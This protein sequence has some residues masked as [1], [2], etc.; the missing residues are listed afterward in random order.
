MKR[1]NFIGTR[2]IYPDLNLIHHLRNTRSKLWSNSKLNLL[3]MFIRE[4]DGYF[5]VVVDEPYVSIF[6]CKGQIFASP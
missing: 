3:S 4:D 6:S 2:I 1:A 5:V